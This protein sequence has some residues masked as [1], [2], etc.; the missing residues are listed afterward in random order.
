[1]VLRRWLSTAL[2]LELRQTE[3][4]AS[5]ME[6]TRPDR[7]TW[8]PAEQRLEK[9]RREASIMFNEIKWMTFAKLIITL[10]QQASR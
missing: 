3:R 9:I 5:K 4:L 1:M 2:A 8:S 7:E 6:L 10:T